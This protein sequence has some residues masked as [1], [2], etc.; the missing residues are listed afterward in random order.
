MMCPVC[1]QDIGRGK[2]G[3]NRQQQQDTGGGGDAATSTNNDN[4]NSSGQQQQHSL[5]FRIMEHAHAAT[6][7]ATLLRPI[8]NLHTSNYG[9]TL[10]RSNR[11]DYEEGLNDSSVT[12]FYSTETTPLI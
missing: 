1:R 3:N 10:L 8:N 4:G 7:P 9:S 5:F 6:A 2:R 11:L 12:S